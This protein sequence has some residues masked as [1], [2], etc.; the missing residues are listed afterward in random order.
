MNHMHAKLTLVQNSGNINRM[1]NLITL[2]NKRLDALDQNISEHEGKRK[3][4]PGLEHNSIKK[5]SAKDG[6]T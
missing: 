1:S 6:T 4:P 5:L 2:C 3:G